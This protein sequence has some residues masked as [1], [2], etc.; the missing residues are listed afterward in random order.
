MVMI[1][2]KG[3]IAFQYNETS[4]VSLHVPFQKASRIDFFFEFSLCPS[5]NCS[6]DKKFSFS[7]YI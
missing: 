6:D 5:E 1:K 3:C 4:H 2:G 7:S